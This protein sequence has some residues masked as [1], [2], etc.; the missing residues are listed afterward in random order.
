MLA[1]NIAFTTKAPPTDD[2]GIKSGS[3]TARDAWLS[4]VPDADVPDVLGK[5]RPTSP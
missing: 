2:A 4:P 3:T 5:A 1:S